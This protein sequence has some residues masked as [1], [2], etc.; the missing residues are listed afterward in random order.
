MKEK[1]FRF[2]R[3][4]NCEKVNIYVKPVEDKSCFS[5]VCGID[6]FRCSF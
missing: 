3:Q 4:A 6:S 5:N 1:D 2:L